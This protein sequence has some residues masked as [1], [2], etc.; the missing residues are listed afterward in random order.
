MTTK[1]PD[2]PIVPQ[3][4]PLAEA[5][6]RLPGNSI[7]GRWHVVLDDG[8]LGDCCVES[9]LVRCREEGDQAGIVLGEL[10]RQM[11]LTQRKKIYQTMDRGY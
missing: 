2:R 4:L 1:N 10:L 8:N 5:Y 11:T 7:G 6:Y 3:V 9:A